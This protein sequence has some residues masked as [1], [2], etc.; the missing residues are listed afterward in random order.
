MKNLF[1]ILAGSLILVLCGW[2]YVQ[3]QK[4]T[5]NEPAHLVVD[6]I[7]DVTGVAQSSPV[8]FYVPFTFFLSR[9]Q[10]TGTVISQKELDLLIPQD[11]SNEDESFNDKL[12]PVDF[13]N[14]FLLY[15]TVE[16]I[17]CTDLQLEPNVYEKGGNH[18]VFN[19]KIFTESACELARFG[20]QW[21]A[22]PRKYLSHTVS[23]ET[24]K[25]KDN[26]KNTIS[27]FL[28]TT[29]KGQTQKQ[30]ENDSTRKLIVNKNFGDTITSASS[31]GFDVVAKQMSSSTTINPKFFLSHE[32]GK[33]HIET[34]SSTRWFD[35]KD[36]VDV[37]IRYP[38]GR[39]EGFRLEMSF[40]ERAV[41][42]EIAKLANLSQE[43]VAKA[44]A[45]LE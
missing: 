12:A 39:E 8:D 4:I 31:T 6:T 22:V 21:V 29:Q 23:F 2:F 24:K 34:R 43:E 40:S 44:T 25:S 35:G 1:Y 7:T 42:D 36:Y 19:V 16:S 33:L 45:F 14:Y 9:R 17:G 41:I 30:Q 38:D 3:N 37:S 5:L 15:Q 28:P 11:T 18:L 27:E 20:V 10:A 32:K 13:D 26:W